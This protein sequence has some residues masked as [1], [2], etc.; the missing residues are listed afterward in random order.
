MQVEPS[1]PPNH[2]LAYYREEAARFWSMAAKASHDIARD[3][4]LR[5]ASFYQEM[6]ARRENHVS[7]RH[8]KD[9]KEHKEQ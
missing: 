1:G 4:W 7:R 5:Y 2:K 9:S 8:Q 6:A 3:I